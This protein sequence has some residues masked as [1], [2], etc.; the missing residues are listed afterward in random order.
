[1]R[2]EDVR[3]IFAR[4]LDAPPVPTTGT[5]EI[6][7]AGR[8]LERRR[9]TLTMGGTV[10]AVAAGIVAVGLILQTANGAGPGSVDGGSPVARWDPAGPADP[11]GDYSD[12][13]GQAIAENIPQAEVDAAGDGPF[14]FAWNE[15]KTAIIAQDR[16][17]LVGHD[18]LFLDVSVQ[19]PRLDGDVDA[20]LRELAGCAE[21]CTLSDFGGGRR[22]LTKEDQVTP[23]DFGPRNRYQVLV[24]RPDGTVATAALRVEDDSPGTIAVTMDQL[25]AVVK[26]IPDASESTEEPEPSDDETNPSNIAAML[27]EAL[28]KEVERQFPGADLTDYTDYEGFDKLGFKYGNT[29]DGWRSDGLIVVATPPDMSIHAEVYDEMSDP[30]RKVP[31]MAKCAAFG[32]CAQNDGPDG[33]KIFIVPGQNPEDFIGVWVVRDDDSIARVTISAVEDAPITI[34]PEQV[35]AIALALPML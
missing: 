32:G 26:A 27:D 5:D 35:T 14:V 16:L 7:V 28:A 4:T 18:T 15:D 24:A 8:R 9:K 6:V 31:N 19:E 13:L 12:S 33:E 11:R 10:T 20:R 22:L 2:E 25:T 30:L 1:M 17:D 3:G 29:I 23:D 21:D 34:T